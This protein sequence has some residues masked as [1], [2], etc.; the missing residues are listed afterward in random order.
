MTKGVP[1]GTVEEWMR[2]DLIN[3]QSFIGPVHHA[4]NSDKNYQRR[5]KFR[6]RER[7]LTCE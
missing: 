6:L 2:L 4:I 3:V 1:I 5:R 7:E